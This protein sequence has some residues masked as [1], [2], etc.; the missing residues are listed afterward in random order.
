MLQSQHFLNLA[1]TFI[2]AL[3]Q[4]IQTSLLVLTSPA[5]KLSAAAT[6]LFPFVSPSSNLTPVPS[7]EA[8]PQQTPNKYF[9]K[10]MKAAAFFFAF[11]IHIHIHVIYMKQAGP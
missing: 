7:K 8:D 3:S 11:Q 5:W 2:C 9:P 10:L 4:P 1:D 6:I